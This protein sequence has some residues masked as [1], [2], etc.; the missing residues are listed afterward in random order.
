LKISGADAKLDKT[1]VDE[2]ADPLMHLVRNS[3]SH[4]IE[5]PDVREARGKPRE[6][7]VALNAFREGDNII[8]EIADDGNGIDAEHIRET[9]AEKRPALHGRH[10]TPDRRRGH[11][12]SFLPPGSPRKKASAP[13]PAAA[14]AW[15]WLRPTSPDWAARVEI[16]TTLGHGSKFSIKLPLTLLIYAASARQRR[17]SR[18]SRFR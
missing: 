5:L 1:V 16:T 18:S 4:G 9:I 2:I 14:S 13:F 3:V 8:I 7:T 17:A 15:T 6:G 11:S 12:S 10:R